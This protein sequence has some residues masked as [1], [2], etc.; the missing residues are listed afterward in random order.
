MLPGC[1]PLHCLWRGE[2][3]AVLA[4]AHARPLPEVDPLR[5]QADGARG[6]PVQGGVVGR[7]AAAL[8]ALG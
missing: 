4:P 7:G 8:V 3:L 2:E 5:V 1:V 6:G